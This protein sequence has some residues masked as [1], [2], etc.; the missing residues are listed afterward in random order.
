MLSNVNPGFRSRFQ[1]HIEFPDWDEDDC[2]AELARTCARE[3]MELQAGVTEYLKV[4]ERDDVNAASL[5]ARC[6][7]P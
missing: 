1:Q 6:T 7:F 3:E 2:M 5:H 4:R